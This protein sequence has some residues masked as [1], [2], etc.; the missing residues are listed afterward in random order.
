M[1]K[2]IFEIY[3]PPRT[4]VGFRTRRTVAKSRAAAF[5]FPK[6]THTTTNKCPVATIVPCGRRVTPDKCVLRFTLCNIIMAE[7]SLQKYQKLDIVTVCFSRVIKIKSNLLCDRKS[8]KKLCTRIS[9]YRTISLF[10][11]LAI[12]GWKQLRKQC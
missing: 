9:N 7:R 5:G 8:I 10:L 11:S 2:N 4:N 12:S 3:C 6:H 1:R